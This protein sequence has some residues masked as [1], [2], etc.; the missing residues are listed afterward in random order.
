[1]FRYRAATVSVV[2]VPECV[3]SRWRLAGHCQQDGL[4]LTE[5]NRGVQSHPKRPSDYDTAI[6]R[7]QTA[8][9]A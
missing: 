6:L 4:C 8:L 1:M 7:E 3:G 2:S 5:T 9:L